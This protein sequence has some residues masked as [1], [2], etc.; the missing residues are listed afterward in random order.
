MK[1]EA[2]VYLNEALD[3]IQEH[4]VRRAY[5]DWQVLRKEVYAQASHAQTP[6]QVYP[7]IKK[8]LFLLDDHHSF[9]SDPESVQLQNQGLAKQFG[10]RIICPEG[11]VGL[12]YPGSPAEQAGVHIGDQVETIN[13]QPMARWSIWQLRTLLVFGYGYNDL[14]LTLKPA[15]KPFVRSVHLQ[16]TAYT[17]I[18]KPERRE[19]AHKIGY[20]DL[21][22]LMGS[23]EQAIEYAQL[24]QQLIRE[25]D[26][27]NPCGWVIDLRRN[28]G[29][30]MWPMVA[31]LG[32]I[33]GEGEWLTF[34]ASQEQQMAFYRDGQAGIS[35][36]TVLVNVER[37]YHLKH[38]RP[39][40]AV[41]TSQLTS[42]SGEF[43][44]LMFRGL[45]RTRSFGEPT[46]GVPTAN[47]HKNLSDG[48][49]LIL[50]TALGADRTGQTYDSPLI[51]DC[52]VKIDWTHLGTPD[53]PV[54]Q[55]AVQ[56]LQVEEG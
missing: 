16:A 43:T 33:V 39:P 5:I 7:A 53:D 46:Q 52:P 47:E 27:S 9:F 22:G 6:A 40:V 45:P 19:I 49:A 41:L 13:G 20:L 51:P 36:D 56:W 26:P 18:R 28:T 44:A 42:S 17:T 23:Q 50:T 32:P 24:T 34:V 14:E 21:P 1:E 29:W 8:A 12:V 55:A 31:G 11:V 38:P 3:Y 10:L 15:G 35:P 30:N 2:R 25:I 4:S 48:A 54:L 37:P